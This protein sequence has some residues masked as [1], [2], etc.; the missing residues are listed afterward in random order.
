M[1]L[2]DLR[3]DTSL[4]ELDNH[5]QSKEKTRISKPPCRASNANPCQ[6]SLNKIEGNFA[7]DREK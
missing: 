5:T 1:F 6:P 7:S 4:K 2:G 3:P